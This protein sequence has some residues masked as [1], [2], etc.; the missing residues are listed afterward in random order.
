M[1][2]MATEMTNILLMLRRDHERTGALLDFLER[3]LDTLDAG[4]AAD[5]GLVRRAAVYFLNYPDLVHHPKEDLVYDRLRR[6]DPAGAESLVNLR[7]EHEILATL[8]RRFAAAAYRIDR[9]IAE[10]G[11]MFGPISRDFVVTYRPHIAMEEVRFFPAALAALTLADWAEIDARGGF[12]PSEAPSRQPP[13]G[14]KLVG[15]E[16]P[17]P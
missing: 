2:V 1:T 11:E 8:T 12:R 15:Q 5:C 3:E 7:A 16:S 6:R 14:V 13:A 17:P 4:G 10:A 9:D